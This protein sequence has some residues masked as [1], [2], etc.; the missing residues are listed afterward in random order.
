MAERGL[1]KNLGIRCSKFGFWS[2]QWWGLL[3]YLSKYLSVC[4]C[5]LGGGEVCDRVGLE[6]VEAE[7]TSPHLMV[8]LRSEM[9]L[10]SCLHSNYICTLHTF[11]SLGNGMLTAFCSWGNQYPWRQSDLA[12]IGQLVNSTAGTRFQTLSFDFLCQIYFFLNELF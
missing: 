7:R 3:L 1:Q 11:N 2:W 8:F 5:V 9:T 6:G 4:M 12:Q 10:L